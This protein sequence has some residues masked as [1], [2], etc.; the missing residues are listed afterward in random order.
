MIFS[1]HHRL[2][3]CD[4]G[5]GSNFQINTASWKLKELRFYGLA[6]SKAKHP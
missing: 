2:F 5:L 6:S 4:V 3:S 1:H